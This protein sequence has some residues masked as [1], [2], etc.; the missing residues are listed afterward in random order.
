M[1]MKKCERCSLK[2][3]KPCYECAAC[4]GGDDHFKPIQQ[5]IK[6]TRADKIRA[7]SDGEL[8]VFFAKTDAALYR[9]ELPII[10]YRGETVNDN[11]EW[12]IEEANHE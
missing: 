9:S 11:L 2:D 10:A 5:R 7:M 1:A 4:V 12:L 6:T 3:A 8:A